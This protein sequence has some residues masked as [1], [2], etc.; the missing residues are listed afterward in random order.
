MK[1]R[2]YKKISQSIYRILVRRRNK[3]VEPE[4]G[5]KFFVRKTVSAGSSKSI[6][7]SRQFDDYQDAVKFR[8]GRLESKMIE[9]SDSMLFRELLELWTQNASKHLAISTQVRYKSYFKHLVFFNEIRVSQITPATIDAYISYLKSPDYLAK[10][11]STRLDYRHELSLLK[12]ILNYYLS[13][14]N[15]NYRMPF[16]KDH[17][18]MA[19]V[20]EGKEKLKD[21]STEDLGKFLQALCDDVMGTQYES[22]FY[23][24]CLQYGLCSRIQEI[25][26]LHFEDFDLNQSIVVVDKKIMWPR[27]KGY[28]TK[29]EQGSKS[30]EGKRIPLSEFAKS[31]FLEWTIKSGVRSGLLFKNADGAPLEYRIIEYRYTKAL[32]SAGLPFRGTHLLRHASLSELYALTSDI[33]V[34]A[35]FAGH[36]SIKTTE[37][38]AK[39]RNPKMSEATALLDEKLKGLSAIVS[40][41]K[42]HGVEG[43]CKLLEFQGLEKVK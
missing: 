16:L 38:Y 12:V 2:K 42:D 29:L 22:I 19:K 1:D 40:K 39:A 27:G 17:N 11:N 35:K 41:S 28:K 37:I 36:A 15:S 23:I 26:A 31:K 8:D 14:Y 5:N 9:E 32:K 6:R 30:N 25:A 34:V 21:L 13:R 33:K 24:A 7:V 43:S 3:W 20:K 10:Q 18:K 4:R